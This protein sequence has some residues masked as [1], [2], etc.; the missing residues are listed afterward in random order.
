MKYISISNLS[1]VAA[2]LLTAGSALAAG[3]T[4]TLQVKGTITPAACTPVLANGGIIDFGATSTSEFTPGSKLILAAKDV[5]LNVTCTAPTKLSFTLTDNREDTSVH[6]STYGAISEMGLGKTTDDKKIGMY[7][8]RPRTAVVDGVAG[9]VI[10]S[11]DAITWATGVDAMDIKSSHESMSIITVANTTTLAP[12]AFEN[13][14]MNI[15]IEPYLSG[16]MSSITEVQQ[17][18]G[19]ATLE[20]DYL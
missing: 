12:I 11:G 3:P 18:D 9:R 4:A 15:N 1:A 16:E 13:M 10:S 8:V 7:L 5:S 2:L 6:L 20:F 14:S 17:L 19:N